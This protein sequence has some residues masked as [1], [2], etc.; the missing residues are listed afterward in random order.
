MTAEIA[1]VVTAIA[2]AVYGLATLLLWFEN[3]EDRKQRD[4]HFREEADGRK[5]NEL[6]SAFY[7]AWGY[8]EGFSHA[9]P[10]SR[11]AAQADRLYEALTRFE[12]Q[13][14]LNNYENQANNLGV[15]VRTNIHGVVKPLADA[16]V[17]LGLLP[18]EYRVVHVA[19]VPRQSTD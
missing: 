18:S 14:R 4:R 12:C 1:I 15:T 16:G 13:L 11:D 2:T 6:R 9:S 7:E 17:A 19:V 3:R 5:L 10:E 8:W